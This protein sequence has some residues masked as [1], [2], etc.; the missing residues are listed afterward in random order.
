MRT[1]FRLCLIA[2]V[3]AAVGL[4]ALPAASASA[5]TGNAAI[6]KFE[7]KQNKKIKKAK[8]KAKK[9]HQ[10][11]EDIKAWN[12]DQ[13][14]RIGAQ[15]DDFLALKSVVDTGVPLI[16]A[17]L[18]DLEEGLL[19]LQA[20]LEDDVA[21]ALEAIDAALNDETT[22]LVGLNLARPQFG[23]FDPAGNFLGGTSDAGSSGPTDDATVSGSFYVIDFENDVSSRVYSVNVFPAGPG[24]APA[25]TS[26]GSCA[27][28]GIDAL[29][30][31]IKAD[32]GDD[33]NQIVVQ[34]GAGASVPATPFT[35][36]AISG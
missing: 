25:V 18:G 15:R 27:T 28:D 22:G 4:V 2:A 34:F 5:A 32:S 10:R 21:P 12:F 9:A 3:I 31:G 1:T 30:E 19:A 11:I 16:T 6:T 24:V 17:A 14:E 8:R 7:K 35:V 33:P 26:I 23:V 36:T 13:D 20:A 29:C